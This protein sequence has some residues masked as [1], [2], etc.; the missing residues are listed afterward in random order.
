[1]AVFLQ[2]SER[3]RV[4]DAPII[5]KTKQFIGSRQD[6]LSLAQGVLVP[7]GIELPLVHII[8]D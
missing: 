3:V 2:M 4:T 1:M 6:V 5:V 8:Y 7:G